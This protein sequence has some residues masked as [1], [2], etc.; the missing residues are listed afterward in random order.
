MQLMVA[1]LLADS[2]PWCQ[3][4][5]P[6][7]PVVKLSSDAVFGP[8]QVVFGEPSFHFTGRQISQMSTT[9]TSEIAA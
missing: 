2:A 6:A 9:L 1:V 4:A 5:N 8:T 7:F 3:E